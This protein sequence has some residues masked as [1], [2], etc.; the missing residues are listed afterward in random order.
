VGQRPLVL[1]TIDS[2]RIPENSLKVE[3]YVPGDLEY[4]HVYA[5]LP[6]S[7][8]LQPYRNDA[9]LCTQPIQVQKRRLVFLEG[10]QSDYFHV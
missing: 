10:K 4:P 5:P 6:P 1:L 7:K 9:Q 3:A 8:L 2:G